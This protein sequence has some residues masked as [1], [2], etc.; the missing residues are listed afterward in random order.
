MIGSRLILFALFIF[1]FVSISPI[2]DIYGAEQ[3]KIT[4]CKNKKEQRIFCEDFDH[5]LKKW[6]TRGAKLEIESANETQ[7]KYLKI[8]RDDRKGF[9]CISREFSNYSGTLRFEARIEAQNIVPGDKDFQ[10]GK[11]QAVVFVDGREVSWPND[12]F[13]GTS[14]EII[15]RFRIFDLTGKENILLR[16]GLQNAKGAVLVDEIE[17]FN[18]PN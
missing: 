18:D 1:I 7:N 14:K 6:K 15:R 10:K 12:D 16:I 17:V 13:E 8:S 5:G 3:Q 4:F 2:A 11:F 9:T